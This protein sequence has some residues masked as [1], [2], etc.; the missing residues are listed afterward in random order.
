MTDFTTILGLARG[1]ANANL[2]VPVQVDSN[3]VL[4][5]GPPQGPTNA[6]GFIEFNADGQSATLFG[7]TEA[8]FLYGF[9]GA[10][11]DRIRSANVFKSVLATASGNTTVWT[12]TAGKKFRLMGYTLSIA[13]TLAATGVELLK[14][15]D[16][17]AG[18]VIA[19]H[20]ATITITTPTGDTQIGADLGNGF[21]S[22]AVN[23]ALVVNLS[24]TISGG[25]AVVNA[26][27]TEE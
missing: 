2:D 27:G 18:T 3:G 9:N 20:Q 17:A 19:Q 8:A 25:G 21:L 5:V 10:S 11:W 14:L 23:N 12:P 4:Q 6:A 22:G 1:G 16:A 26:W 13:G 7:V 15:T 24:A